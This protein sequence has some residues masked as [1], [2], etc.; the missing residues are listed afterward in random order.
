[1]SSS[2]N[3]N[4]SKSIDQENIFNKRDKD[5]IN[6]KSTNHCLEDPLASNSGNLNSYNNRQENYFSKTQVKEDT[7]LNFSLMYPENSSSQTELDQNVL[8]KEILNYSDLNFEFLNINNYS[9]D[10][11]PDLIL[12]DV[13]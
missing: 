11:T 10:V 9:V 5:N 2:K 3:S 6:T 7:S 8:N 4:S 1:M 12:Q 13:S